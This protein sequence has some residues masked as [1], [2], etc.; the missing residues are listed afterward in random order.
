M[1]KKDLQ[2]D[3]CG[4]DRVGEEEKMSKKPLVEVSMESLGDHT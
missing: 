3:C 4:P 2:D 1:E